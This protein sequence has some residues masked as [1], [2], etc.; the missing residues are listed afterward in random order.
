MYE[1]TK[2][3]YEISIWEDKLVEAE[4]QSY[5]LADDK[6]PQE[7]TFYKKDGNNYIK[8][9]D[10]EN[11]EGDKYVRV[12]R[13]L[14][15]FKEEKIAVIG[16]NNH[17]APELAYNPKFIDDVKGEH[18]LTFTMNGKYYDKEL[19]TF[20]DN[21]YIKYLTN[22]R[23]VKLYFR[24]NWYDLIIKKVEENKKNYS[25]TYTATDLFINELG[26]NGFKVELDTELENN[27]GTAEELAALVLGDTDWKVS[28]YTDE[29]DYKSDL[30]VETN[31]D[32]LYEATLIKDIL[33]KVSA[34]GWLPIREDE[35]EPPFE[36]DENGIGDGKE[37]TII[38]KGEKVYLFY[39]DLIAKN[40]E[41][42]V[43]Y[44]KN[45]VY[46]TNE[47][48]D[49]II[50]SYNFRVTRENKVA[51]SD[52]DIP[53]P[54]FIDINEGI[55]LEDTCRAYET[56]RRPETGYDP[57]TDEFVTYFL[58]RLYT[59]SYVLTEDVVPYSNKSYFIK[60]EDN[61]LRFYGF[62]FEEGIEYYEERYVEFLSEGEEL[63]DNTQYY[64]KSLVPEYVPTL[65][66]SP[67][68]NKKYF[69][70]SDGEYILCNTEELPLDDYGKFDQTDFFIYEQ[71]GKTMDGYI[72]YEKSVW[73]RIKGYTDT[74][75]LS[76][77]LVQNYLTNSVEI[78][79]DG[80]GW[81]FDGAP[82]SDNRAGEITNR[83]DD[84]TLSDPDEDP[85]SSLLILHLTDSPVYYASHTGE[86]L[87]TNYN[88]VEENPAI[89]LEEFLGDIVLFE[90]EI[91]KGTKPEEATN[92]NTE[93][94]YCI[95]TS[96]GYY[97]AV[98]K[99]YVK[100]N[101]VY[102]HIL[103]WDGLDKDYYMWNGEEY[104]SLNDVKVEANRYVPNAEYYSAEGTEPEIF[105]SKWEFLTCDYQLYFKFH[106]DITEE[107][108]YSV[109][110]YDKAT[111]IYKF[112]KITEQEPIKGKPYYKIDTIN[113]T[114][115][116][117][118]IFVLINRIDF[119]GGVNEYYIKDAE[120]RYKKNVADEPIEGAIYYTFKPT[121]KMN[122]FPYETYGS[123]WENAAIR[124]YLDS[125]FLTPDYE[126]YTYF[127]KIKTSE[128]VPD[129]SYWIKR[130]DGTYQEL[131][132]YSLTNYTGE[133][134]YEKWEEDAIAEMQAI[135]R[136]V[137]TEDELTAY[138]KDLLN[139]VTDL[140][141]WADYNQE[142]RLEFLNAIDLF[143]IKR[144]M[145]LQKL[146]TLEKNYPDVEEYQKKELLKYL[147]V[148]DTDLKQNLRIEMSV[149]A[150][151]KVVNYFPTQDAERVDGK[152][153]YCFKLA[154]HSDG[155]VSRTYM[156]EEY[157]GDSFYEVEIDGVIYHTRIETASGASEHDLATRIIYEFEGELV[158]LISDVDSAIDAITDTEKTNTLYQVEKELENV[159]IGSTWTALNPFKV[160]KAYKA[161]L[162]VK[163]ILENGEGNLSEE[164]EQALY[165]L[166]CKDD[167]NGSLLELSDS[168]I[169]FSI[170]ALFSR[171]R[172][173]ANVF[174]LLKFVKD[175]INEE[176]QEKYVNLLAELQKVATGVTYIKIDTV[177]EDPDPTEK[178]FVKK[179]E[180]ISAQG[181]VINPSEIYYIN[182]N[183]NNEEIPIYSEMPIKFINVD[184]DGK[185]LDLVYRYYEGPYR[186][187][188][189]EV[190]K[191]ETDNFGTPYNYYIQK[192][193]LVDYSSDVE[194]SITLRSALK[195]LEEIIALKYDDIDE[196][197]TG[198]R[199]FDEVTKALTGFT[200]IWHLEK[201]ERE[202]VVEATKLLLEISKQLTALQISDDF[203]G[204]SNDRRYEAHKR[205]ALN[206]G[207]SAN[208]E[209]IKKLNKGEEYVFALSLGRYYEGDEPPVYNKMSSFSYGDIENKYYYFDN[210][211][212]GIG[213]Y[214]L[215][216]EDYKEILPGEEGYGTP[217]GWAE[218]EGNYELA[219]LDETVDPRFYCI[220]QETTEGRF[221]T[222]FVSPDSDELNRVFYYPDSDGDYIYIRKPGGLFDTQYYFDKID[223]YSWFN[224]ELDQ[225]LLKSGT[226]HVLFNHPSLEAKRFR[227]S[228][229]YICAK[230]NT[231]DFIRDEITL[232]N[233]GIVGAM[234]CGAENFDANNIQ[235]FKRSTDTNYEGRHKK[236]KVSSIEG[237]QSDNDYYK[238]LSLSERLQGV[239]EDQIYYIY[240]GATKSYE[241]VEL[242]NYFEEDVDYY[243]FTNDRRHFSLYDV[244]D[245]LPDLFVFIPDNNGNYVHI[246]RKEQEEQVVTKWYEF[247]KSPDNLNKIYREF[248]QEDDLY[249]SVPHYFKRYNGE[250]DYDFHAAAW[251]D[252]HIG[253]WKEKYQRYAKYRVHLYDNTQLDP[254]FTYWVSNPFSD[255]SECYTLYDEAPIERYTIH[256]R[257]QGLVDGKH[258]YLTI[259]EVR[260]LREGQLTTDTANPNVNKVTFTAP[261]NYRSYGTDKEK[262]SVGEASFG[263]NIGLELIP[264]KIS[265]R[266]FRTFQNETDSQRVPYIMLK[267]SD[268]INP[269]AG[270]DWVYCKGTVEGETGYYRPCT[271]DDENLYTNWKL[272]ETVDELLG[273]YKFLKIKDPVNWNE[274][275]P[276][277]TFA[278]PIE[279]S[280]LSHQYA[281]RIIKSLNT[282]Y[283]WGRYRYHEI[284]KTNN[285]AGEIE[286]FIGLLAEFWD[287]GNRKLDWL[288]RGLTNT[289]S[290][291]EFVE[292]YKDISDWFDKRWEDLA[293]FLREVIR[294]F[295]LSDE[296]Y[297]AN[298]L[299]NMIDSCGID[300]LANDI[301]YVKVDTKTADGTPII[302]QEGVAYYA[303]QVI[304]GKAGYFEQT[305]S[306]DEN[307]Y[308][309][310]DQTKVYYVVENDTEGA[311]EKGFFKD[312]EGVIIG[313]VKYKD[314]GNLIIYHYFPT[315]KSGHYESVQYKNGEWVNKSG[316]TISG[317]QIYEVS[318]ADD[319][320]TV[321]GSFVK[322]EG[323]PEANKIYYWYNPSGHSEGEI[324]TSA[325]RTY[326]ARAYF[327]DAMY[328]LYGSQW[329]NRI[330]RSSFATGGSAF[331]NTEDE[332]T[333]TVLEE[334][335]S[336]SELW[337]KETHAGFT[338]FIP[339]DYTLHGAKTKFYRHTYS[340]QIKDAV[341]GISEIYYNDGGLYKYYLS[342]DKTD[343]FV[344]INY[345]GLKVS[346]CEYDYNGSEYK[347]N[348]VQTSDSFEN[349]ENY[350]E[351]HRN[352][353]DFD[354]SQ[355]INGYFDL[356]ISAEVPALEEENI[357]LI[358]GVKERYV[359]WKAPVKHNYNLTD[360]LHSKVGTLF[361]TDSKS[362]KNYPIASA[363]LF[364]YKSYKSNNYDIL[365]DFKKQIF[366]YEQKCIKGEILEDDSNGIYEPTYEE[367]KIL[368]SAF[369]GYFGIEEWNKVEAAMDINY[370]GEQRKFSVYKSYLDM[371]NTHFA[372]DGTRVNYIRDRIVYNSETGE[373]E[374]K[375]N[376]SKP[377]PP[378]VESQIDTVYLTLEYYE[379][380]T[381]NKDTEELEWD[382]NRL[383]KTVYY[384]A[385]NL[386]EYETKWTQKDLVLKIPN[387]ADS[388]L[389]LL[390]SY[391]K[392]LIQKYSMRE[393]NQEKETPDIND[394]YYV[395][396]EIDGK[397]YYKQYNGLSVYPTSKVYQTR[398]LTQIDIGKATKNE[399]DSYNV[400]TRINSLNSSG[401]IKVNLKV[402][403][404]LLDGIVDR[405]VYAPETYT[406]VPM[407]VNINEGS[408]AEVIE[409]LAED[410]RKDY[411]TFE[412][413]KD[414]NPFTQF[415]CS[416]IESE[417][418]YAN[419]LEI[420]KTY[421][422]IVRLDSK[423]F[424]GHHDISKETEELNVIS[425]FNQKVEEFTNNWLAEQ[426]AHLKKAIASVTQ[427]YK[428]VTEEITEGAGTIIEEI[429]EFGHMIEKSFTN[430]INKA[431][432][433]F[434]NWI[435]GT[436]SY[437]MFR[438]TRT[439]NTNLNTDKAV[440][441]SISGILS[442][443]LR[444]ALVNQEDLWANNETGMVIYLSQLAAY[445]HEIA[446]FII[447]IQELGYYDFLTDV[448]YSNDDSFF[449]YFEANY[450]NNRFINR[451]LTGLYKEVV[452]GKTIMALPGEVPDNNDLIFTNYYLYQP[453]Q[454]DID[455]LV[456]DYVGN[457]ALSYYI[458]DYDDL[459]QKVR[460]IEIKEKNYL[461]ALS[462]INEKFECWIK[463]E[464]EHYTEEENSQ[465]SLS[466]YENAHTPGEVKMTERIVWI[467]EDDETDIFFDPINIINTHISDKQN[468]V[469]SALSQFNPRTY[470]YDE[471]KDQ[472]KKVEDSNFHAFEEN[473]DYYTLTPTG[474]FRIVDKLTIPIP[475][476]QETYYIK[477]EGADEDK[478]KEYERV[479]DKNYLKNILMIPIKTIY[480]KQFTGDLNY[481]GFKYGINLKSIKR[482]MDSKDFVSR[483]IVKENINE[484]AMDGFCTIQRATENPIKESFILNFDYYVQH[485]MLNREELWQDLYGLK[486]G[487][488][489][490]L[491]K[492]NEG[493]EDLVDRIA[494]V[495]EC[496]DRINANYETYSL[497]RDAA[498]EEIEKMAQILVDCLPEGIPSPW[499][500]NMAKETE[501]LRTSWSDTQTKQFTTKDKD[502]NIIEMT[503][504]VVQGQSR[505]I[506][507]PKY[508]EDNQKK[509][510]QMDVFQRNHVRYQG[511]A[512]KAKEQKE[513]Y[514]SKLKDLYAESD[515]MYRMKNNLNLM[516]FK[517]Y[518]RFIQ[519]GS[520]KDDNYIDD[521]L[522]YLD[523]LAV[524]RTSAFPKVTYDIQVID[525]ENLDDYKGYSFNIGDKTYIEDT[526][527]FGYTQSKKPYQEETIV[528]KLEYHLDDASKNKITVTNYKTQF[529]DMFK[530]IA[531][532]V[533]KVELGTGAYNRANAVINET[534]LGA[535]GA[536][537]AINGI[538]ET[539][540][541]SVSLGLEGLVTTE[542]GLPSNKI[543]IVNGAIYRSIDGG[544]TYQKIISA[545]GGIDPSLVGNGTLDLTSLTIGSK[546]SPE[547]ALTANGMTAFR[548][549][550]D[551]VDYST[552]VRF[553]SYGMYGIK[554][555]KRNS[556]TDDASNA[557]LNDVFVP[558]D[559]DSIY[560]NASYGLTW[561]GFFL[562]TG[563]GT[564]RVTIGTNQD[565]R[566]ST[567][568]SSDAWQDRIVIGKLQNNEEEYYG[569]RIIDDNNNIVLN[570][571]D[572]GQLYLR[573]KL[574]ISH[575]ND[576]MGT[577]TEG[578]T[579][580]DKKLGQT[581]VT[582]GIVKAYKRNEDGGYDKGEDLHEDYSSLDYLTKV[583]SVKSAVDGYNLKG[584]LKE[585]KE[586][587]KQFTQAQ[588]STLIDSNE[589]LAIFDNGNLYAKNAWIEGNIRATSGT[590][591]GTLTAAKLE[592]ITFSKENTVAIGGSIFVRPTAT[593][594]DFLGYNLDTRILTVITD[595]NDKDDTDFLPGIICEIPLNLSNETFIIIEKYFIDDKE[596]EY[597]NNK[598]LKLQ[599]IMFNTEITSDMVKNKPL[600][601]YGGVNY[602]LEDCE[603][604]TFSKDQII[605]KSIRIKKNM[606][607]NK[608]IVNMGALRDK[609]LT[610]I[611]E[612]YQYNYSSN[613][614]IQI[615]MKDEE[616]IIVLNE[617]EII[618]KEYTPISLLI[619]GGVSCISIVSSSSTIN[620][621]AV[622]LYKVNYP[623]LS[624]NELVAILEG[625]PN[626]DFLGSINYNSI[627]G[628]FP[629][630]LELEETSGLYTENGIFYGKVLNR[631]QDGEKGVYS[632]LDS[633]SLTTPNVFERFEQ[634]LSFSECQKIQ[635]EVGNI[636]F[637][638][639]ANDKDKDA[640]ALAPFIVDSKGNMF[641]NNAYITNSILSNSTIRGSTLEVA[642]IIGSGEE[643]ALIIKDSKRG[644]V[645]VD[646]NEKESFSINKNSL[647]SELETLEFKIRENGRFLVS[648]NLSIGEEQKQYR[649]AYNKNKEQIGINLFIS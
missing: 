403:Y 261:P 516:F 321:F 37:A 485:G 552:F 277:F 378:E 451:L 381:V 257:Y 164:D 77:T 130:A 211:P 461:S 335:Y 203:I 136:F 39:S 523:A 637:W 55:R 117:N 221:V 618:F 66:E 563:D 339:F 581:N 25:Y 572:R 608:E 622:S 490:Q 648:T 303:I 123:I 595:I 259:D 109:V 279:T 188:P 17:N 377:V 384:G 292:P 299:L 11:Y 602:Q 496:L 431:A 427:G 540:N 357:E 647:I 198:N 108:F 275:T 535:T 561:N 243:V 474:S 438:M 370:Q 570:T 163:Y 20:V 329:S 283:W 103:R 525:L 444:N 262:L 367:Y 594:I 146:R 352:Y 625:K 291:A 478:I 411:N 503:E 7:E 400:T 435:S 45:S 250:M 251:K 533:S 112:S 154:D 576:E 543:R 2:D 405:F 114:N 380:C 53:L 317:E 293:A 35:V 407:W 454:E 549:T 195:N 200:I 132:E 267:T 89:S 388:N 544:A 184:N 499:K 76:P 312:P 565:F 545:E 118:P 46:V 100:E 358:K 300:I 512:K 521:T 511:L 481:A 507:I 616:I 646:E 501:V 495:N 128:M 632:G 59:L 566:M 152:H 107:E 530:R 330:E 210:D 492:I 248:K 189:Y 212:T 80:A 22:E 573:H 574:H 641:S 85:T 122:Y 151:K 484:H 54:N 498:E 13:K 534:G 395:I 322:F 344:A 483:L 165:A 627:L 142:S 640:I 193:S 273:L 57:V 402:K 644:I 186:E 32:T 568:N 120:D 185:I 439:I 639:G 143:G 208:R 176:E 332:F 70:Y 600:I 488:Y 249:T 236:D 605:Y 409:G 645:I 10:P 406:E 40:T 562:N 209:V 238:K 455:T 476:G 465:L 440:S 603:I 56:V 75:Y 584:N 314:N 362:L 432:K 168:Q 158:D 375:F 159:S 466:E 162:N 241:I 110:N 513:L 328:G 452:T 424:S 327:W 436:S 607:S 287:W 5:S 129:G 486:K 597:Y 320:E 558:K 351:Y 592:A 365:M 90:K 27:Q 97:Q 71:S 417:L 347:I 430:G 9:E 350:S 16:A 182:K 510:E 470:W 633:N 310:F 577:I 260:E 604:G 343:P 459:C 244:E 536:S 285:K 306:R 520:W 364:K 215:G 621:Q 8:L 268:N 372:E 263:L 131:D 274:N 166:F 256:K 125:V 426:E 270:V 133:Y 286:T 588:L 445:Y 179:E 294:L 105:A 596:S 99:I 315:E 579:I 392:S 630:E 502:G 169:L 404:E 96:N 139:L 21:P 230:A 174:E 52:D 397:P 69:I 36:V 629:K 216:I 228:P 29:A 482:T 265:N 252:G 42:M 192:R 393:V 649:A 153:Y 235:V 177:N 191:W 414:P 473:V 349:L 134:I 420:G 278:T 213:D 497:A 590:F 631:P 106:K 547:L 60:E 231:D 546:N 148:L 585:K 373:Y 4:E 167:E 334:I 173:D 487:Y 557:N 135:Y 318:L 44:R 73:S 311:T 115:D 255:G 391:I 202:Q 147:R 172:I 284:G 354:C 453:G 539:I 288:W 493:L 19:E 642:T 369:Q 537:T 564:G 247:W 102:K 419:N 469:V 95:N 3:L 614:I 124:D 219:G 464:L 620:N 468:E 567:K 91:Y 634:L 559:I 254:L 229:T 58:Q 237:I 524:A 15:F 428:E 296:D 272:S 301:D 178:Y 28:S 586:Y 458:Y 569:F 183:S 371:L 619:E 302:P 443:E 355:P 126:I 475:D 385:E 171:S 333:N 514:E 467:A 6:T 271:V 532:A 508:S 116:F 64:V 494:E 638:A 156:A 551:V 529:E 541:G 295:D 553:D 12:P 609:F 527:F 234:V 542:I 359:W 623:V 460:G 394:V 187:V 575:F 336:F 87:Y 233:K 24:D 258:K 78:S 1:V 72:K 245:R 348:P 280:M 79:G 289:S 390:N 253:P 374:F 612:E 463:Y 345:D 325:N 412:R 197:R 34:D 422:V 30:L 50:N 206:T 337:V 504:H 246:I 196:L 199:V 62:V 398:Y 226:W 323:T 555:Y 84:P 214:V 368:K 593:I 298:A 14:S 471:I 583:F 204:L 353:L 38:P 509:L 340:G 626:I 269:T 538:L 396:N 446:T 457:D 160:Y 43:L 155:E 386:N 220:A 93:V 531:A 111:P 408:L 456:Y 613:D 157:L 636:V 104:E 611:Q 522:Y 119:L 418:L 65:D 416:G 556:S 410:R 181:E 429:V 33:I 224:M 500:Y 519:E 98:N 190:E 180:W 324:D 399:D 141:D 366:D 480:L 145:L 415:V 121:G 442:N 225:V 94:F 477:I 346:F 554:G 587:F 580:K 276:P 548:K 518:Y 41:P 82:S 356:T 223:D 205:R 51:Y 425:S 591:T 281:M 307:G 331:L 101:G 86:L 382:E 222:R 341:D 448:N 360:D 242:T 308:L 434:A 437:S 361:Y 489:S 68:S 63:T 617:E 606:L 550:N 389:Y 140:L 379:G 26:K 144:A 491:A 338:K 383:E 441:N 506:E 83:L 598:V 61:Y 578:D 290:A 326:E 319:T 643:P 18:T 582:L 413:G 387:F 297:A 316:K 137:Y 74:E 47:N 635:E 421:E 342:K 363:Q 138:A 150:D 201:E 560:E 232:E 628:N 450:S 282:P 304:D 227:R 528:T 376:N 81:L 240:N 599:R 149:I 433:A 624:G 462:Q 515:N 175:R 31:L 88:F 309:Q 266:A 194:Y 48:E 217:Y 23:K 526:E 423:F 264:V 505:A 610:I 218:A 601:N 207:F 449:D 615:I 472:F 589:N 170:Q 239:Q 127:N 401:L 67:L 517:K 161:L 49:I 113:T 313:I 447:Y 571:D 305:L 92:N 479:P